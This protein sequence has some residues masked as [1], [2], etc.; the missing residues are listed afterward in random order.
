MEKPFQPKTPTD[1]HLAW[2][3]SEAMEGLTAVNIRVA[4]AITI[5]VQMEV[6]ALQ[7][8]RKLPKL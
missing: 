7:E 3:T 1:F 6:E 4:I 2:I 5:L 8:A